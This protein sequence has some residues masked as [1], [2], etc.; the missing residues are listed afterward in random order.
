M[1]S[2]A[3]LSQT[4]LCLGSQEDTKRDL[5]QKATEMSRALEGIGAELGG[6]TSM[7]PDMEILLKT[8]LGY[9]VSSGPVRHHD[10]LAHISIWVL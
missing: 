2:V 4:C 8:S 9:I 10:T 7:T 6:G 3:Y 5:R 1:K